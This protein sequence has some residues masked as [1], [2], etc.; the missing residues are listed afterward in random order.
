[1]TVERTSRKRRIGVVKKDKME[2][3][4]VVEVERRVSHPIYKKVIKLYK[5]FI[6]HDPNNE[7][8]VGD[9]VEIAETRPLSKTKRW[10]LCSILRQAQR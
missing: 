10:R 5:K 9:L 1:M 2:K 8:K 6:V 3:S 4:I 7:A